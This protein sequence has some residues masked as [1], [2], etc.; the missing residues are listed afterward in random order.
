MPLL[1][2]LVLPLHLLPR[3]LH[4]LPFAVRPLD[5][6]RGDA[7]RRGILQPEFVALPPRLFRGDFPLQQLLVALVPRFQTRNHP[8][9]GMDRGNRGQ[10]GTQVFFAFHLLDLTL[11]FRGRGEGGGGGGRGAG[12]G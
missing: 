4:V 10:T 6:Q 7:D 11:I 3:F 9:G 8:P 5:A 2:F 12:R 1:P